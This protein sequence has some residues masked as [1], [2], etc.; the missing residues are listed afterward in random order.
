MFSF[1]VYIANLMLIW[2]IHFFCDGTHFFV[3]N[4]VEATG[5]EREY[6]TVD[7]H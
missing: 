5:Y 7:A 1:L 3:I 2:C 4:G 6:E